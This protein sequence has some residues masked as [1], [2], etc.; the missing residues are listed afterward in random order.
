M[1]ATVA[2]AQT[3]AEDL[4]SFWVLIQR[5]AS[6]DWFRVIA[7]SDLSLTQLKT[8]M[9]PESVGRQAA[10]DARQDIIAGLSQAAKRAGLNP[11][12]GT[13]PTPVPN[14]LKR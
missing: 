5:T 4:N 13:A 11:S 3:L 8:L 12:G 2:P 10:L 6:S 9:H 1:H 7:E 14:P